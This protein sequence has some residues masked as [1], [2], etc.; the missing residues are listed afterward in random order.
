[1]I[2]DEIIAEFQVLIEDVCVT[3]V[4]LVVC[5]KYTRPNVVTVPTQSGTKDVI[6]RTA[7][8]IHHKID[9]FHSV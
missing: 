3:L 8:I 6:Y 9:A 1:M 4:V 5:S 7:F 2:N